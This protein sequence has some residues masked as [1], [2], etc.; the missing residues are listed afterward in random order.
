MSTPR[1]H[2]RKNSQKHR[3][4]K[5]ETQ[6]AADAQ[7][8][9]DHPGA[10]DASADNGASGP[11]NR[12]I[13]EN[14]ADIRLL[15]RLRR[16]EDWVIPSEARTKL[17]ANLYRL[18]LPKDEIQEG[19][20]ERKETTQTTT[21]RELRMLSTANVADKV[22]SQNVEFSVHRY[23]AGRHSHAETPEL[24]QVA[25]ATDEAEPIAFFEKVSTDE[26][27]DVVE[28]LQQLGL[29]ELLLGIDQG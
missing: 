23:Y 16:R 8:F 17:P 12:P 13:I 7:G 20:S 21:A 9:D 10:I 1:I 25:A 11:H 26:S 29:L 15:G 19:E 22:R 6:A 3:R 2:H 24:D 14:H 5:P 4:P 27:A 18:T 28:E